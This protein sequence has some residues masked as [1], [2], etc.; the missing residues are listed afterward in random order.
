[1]HAH[2]YKGNLYERSKNF[3]K[4]HMIPPNKSH[5]Q[6]VIPC[7]CTCLQLVLKKVSTGIPQPISM[8]LC[9]VIKVLEAQMNQGQ[10]QS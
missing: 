6:T 1:M 2:K 7:V 9:H 5:C 10:G 8:K 3:D 4:R